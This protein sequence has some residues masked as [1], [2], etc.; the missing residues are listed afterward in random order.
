MRL[1]VGLL[2]V[3]PVGAI[4]GVD[5]RVARTAI[6]LAPL[7]GLLLGVIAATVL[8]GV[9]ALV[10]STLG[11]L[12]AAVLAIATLAYLTRAL[13]LDGLADTADALGSGRRGDAALEI[14]R[15]G[16]VGPFGVVTVLLVLLAQ[17]A[18]LA[19]ASDAGWGALTLI[20]AVVTGRLGAMVACSRGIPAASPE[21]LGALVAGTVPRTAALAWVVIALGLAAAAGAWLTGVAWAPALA[22]IA[23]LALALGLVA[24]SAGR[25]GGINGDVL[26]A[27]VETS[28][29]IAI[30]VLAVGASV[31]A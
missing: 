28:T 31:S 15:R 18:A 29:T 26:G 13:H 23:G 27:A 12:L 19:V 20:V 6:L 7:V 5:R 4:D 22:V 9:R 11:A 24:R 16:D 2:T 17:V 21:G 30:V 14:A 25:L 10:P 3:I 1:S 8:V